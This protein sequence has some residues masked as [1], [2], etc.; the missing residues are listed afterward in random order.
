M[1]LIA[2][3]CCR[4]DHRHWRSDYFLEQRYASP[5]GSAESPTLI[6]ESRANAGLKEGFWKFFVSMLLVGTGYLCLTLCLAEMTSMMPFAG[7]APHSIRTGRSVAHNGL[8]KVA[9]LAT[10]GALWAP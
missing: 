2:M 5:C 9:P 6:R 8:S 7:E 4:L 3:W 10:S 1:W